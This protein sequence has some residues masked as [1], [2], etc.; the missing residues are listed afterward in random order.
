MSKKLVQTKEVSTPTSQRAAL[1]QAYRVIKEL[2]AKLKASE[3]ALASSQKPEPIAII[4]LGGRFPGAPDPESF[5]QLL[6]DGV[7]ATSE[8]PAS[9]WDIDAYYDPN[10]EVLG[11]MYTR[12]GGF[13]SEIDGFDTNFF[14]ISPREAVSLDP[15]QRLLLEVTWEAIE[16]AGI[17]ADQLRESNTGVYI[18]HAPMN[19]EY[20]L[21]DSTRFHFDQYTQTGSGRSLPA[22]RLS[23]FRL[24]GN[25]RQT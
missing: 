24:F 2:K 12:R 5:W 18:G 19:G 13:L 25:L 1:L 16:N 9:R 23:Y 4:G 17:A 20:S 10:K 7:D 22:G 6:R 15:A 21:I 14:R 8:V 3:E 11:K